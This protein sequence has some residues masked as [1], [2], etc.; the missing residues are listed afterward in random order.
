MSIETI[1][2]QIEKLAK[3]EK[4]TKALL[5]ELSRTILAY[6]Y[7]SGDVTP[8]NRLLYV[9]TPMNKRTAI[10]YFKAFLSWRFDADLATFT[11]K[12]KKTFEQK[13][14]ATE[15]FLLEESNNIFTWSE[16]NIDIEPKKVD[17]NK[18]LTNDF[19]KALE[20]GMTVDQVLEILN[21]CIPDE[22]E[23]QEAA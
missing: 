9:L 6:V 18:R 19:K 5:S 10:V 21:S 11:K 22:I 17:W 16:D 8:V 23:V 4:V 3:S 14:K 1:N 7:S 2:L 15:I 13:Q 20:D 12:N